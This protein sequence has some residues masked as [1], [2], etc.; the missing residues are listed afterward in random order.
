MASLLAKVAPPGETMGLGRKESIYDSD[1]LPSGTPVNNTNY[2]QV[3]T[4]FTYQASLP[5]QKQNSLGVFTN[6]LSAGAQS[7]LP[8]GYKF[9][10]YKIR[11]RIHSVDDDP[12][13]FVNWAYWAECRVLRQIMDFVITVDQSSYMTMQA[14]DLTSWADNERLGV[15]GSPGV[16]GYALPTPGTDHEGRALDVNGQP[17]VQ[18]ALDNWRVQGQIPNQIRTGVNNF[19]PTVSLC[20]TVTLDGV[21]VRPTN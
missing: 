6:L 15:V 1:G 3:Y 4:A 17:W 21:L 10:A 12:T 5:W 8:S 13:V 11:A 9:G 16:D 2:F 7:F 14:N 19:S 20:I 18:N